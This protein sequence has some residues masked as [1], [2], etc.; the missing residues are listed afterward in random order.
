MWLVLTA[1]RRPITI[2]VA[3]LAIVLCSTL[4]LRRMQVDIFPNLGAPAIYV[5]APYGGMS[6]AQMES[7]ITYNFEYH[8]FYIAGID[9]VESKTTQ[10][11]ALMKLVFRP[12]TDMSQALAQVVASVNRSRAFTPPGTVPPF[13]TRFDAGSVPVAQL[14]FSSPTRGVGEMQEIAVTRVRPLF[15]SLPGVSAPP[16]FGASQRTLVV[17]LDTERM[18]SFRLSPEEAILAIN[19]ATSIQP[20]G[21][22]RIGNFNEIASV[23]ASVGSDFNELMNAPVRTGS[24]TTVYVRDIGMVELGTDITNGFAHVN[25]RRTVYIPVTKR[26]DAS[27]LAVIARVKEA[28]PAMRAVVPED[29]NIQLEF[30]QSSYVARAIQGLVSEG[31]V[32]A[33]LTGL[34]V[35][36]FLRDW[37]SAFIVVTTIPFALLAAVVWLWALGQTINIMTLG[38]LAL[39]VGVL[40]DEATVEIENIHTHMATGMPRALS[41]MEACRKT[42]VPRLLAMLSILSVFV[43]SFFMVG[44]GRQLFVP[45][46]LAV[47]FAMVSS[48]LLSSTLVPVLSIW[49]MRQG[50]AREESAGLFGRFRAGYGALVSGFLRFRWPLVVGY[51][52]V[53]GGFLFFALPE[54]GKEIFPLVEAGQL[55]LRIRAEPGTRIERTEVIALKAL[56]VIKSEVGA[57]NVSI[58]TGYIGTQPSG[59]PVNSIY[60]WTSGPQEAVLRVALNPSTALHGEALK[61][62]LRQRLQAIM[63]DSSFSFEPGDIVSQVMSFGSPTPVEVAVQGPNI[64][65]NR[66]H[67]EKIRLELKKLASLR[68]LQYAQPLD[69]PTVEVKVDRNRAGQFGLT[70]ASV[71]RSLVAATSSSRFIEPNYWRDPATGNSFQIQVEIPQNKMAS[72]DDVLAVP[73]STGGQ[74]GDAGRSPLLRDVAEAGRSKTMG[75]IDR[76]NMQRVVS[77]T[78]NTHDAALGQVADQVRAAI[79]RAGTPPRGATVSV[80]G[81]IP[82]F[83]E[84]LSGLRLG[85]LLSIVIIFLLLAGNF[86]SFRLAFAVVSTLPAVIGGVLLMLLLTRTTL[87]VQSF[88]GAIM[89]IGIAVANAILLVTFAEMSRREGCS[90]GDAA[91]AGAKSRLRAILMTAA[92]MIAGMA[93]IAFGFGEGSEQTAPLGRAVIGGLLAATAATLL[94]LPAVYALLQRRASPHSA[95]LHPHDPESRY[96]VPPEGSTAR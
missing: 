51:A 48:Y 32:G 53:T 88:M 31:M 28:L 10:G 77:V 46:S 87:N 45:L 86:Q 72:T 57:Q 35:L 20:A 39:A 89:S 56:E 9:H 1:L 68:D 27:T 14:V 64:E 42:A 43:P 37:R 41:V 26:A 6:P 40:V 38:G 24:G 70:M 78:A 81:Q 95:S 22:L 79:Q 83:E 65:A 49:V 61:E 85:L 3:V 44:V 50:G 91:V 94:V 52:A 59:N 13:V 16:P 62:R 67:C 74:S 7:F 4:A 5:A 80:R 33:L 60:L 96:Y 47:G 58:S 2:L 11:I 71:A 66:A 93:P 92:A 25:G 75:Q 55:Q 23:N 19:R 76:Y 17:R 36:L 15:A 69:Y 63:P 29:V 54:I 84:T 90:P 12:E 34:M 8:F 82:A 18:R 30:D 73:L 21:N